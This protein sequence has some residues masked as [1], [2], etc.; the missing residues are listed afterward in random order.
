[1]TLDTCPLHKHSN[2]LNM[3]YCFEG[4]KWKQV[5]GFPNY[6]ISNYGRLLSFTGKDKAP[7]IRKAVFTGDYLAATLSH[8]GVVKPYYIHRLVIEHFVKKVENKNYTNHI[9]GIKT[10]NHYKNLEWVNHSENGL[11]AYR[12]GL[13]KGPHSCSKKYTKTEN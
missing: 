1:M 6:K 3:T 8:N 4:E 5:K 11:H 13:N 2:Y 10:D 7:F 9:N 12:L